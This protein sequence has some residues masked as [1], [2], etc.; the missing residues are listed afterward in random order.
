MGGE[1]WTVTKIFYCASPPIGAHSRPFD[2]HDCPSNAPSG[3][4][5]R[6]S[7]TKWPAR[8]ASLLSG[9]VPTSGPLQIKH[10]RS[11]KC[12]KWCRNGSLIC[13]RSS[14]R[15]NRLGVLAG[16]GSSRQKGE[17]RKTRTTRNGG[18][19]P[20]LLATKGHPPSVAISLL[21]TGKEHNNSNHGLP[22]CQNNIRA[23]RPVGLHEP[24]EAAEASHNS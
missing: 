11:A 9:A 13:G 22:G 6:T 16:D 10:L 7:S 8:C 19:K 4:W 20:Q 14:G 17:P 1:Q 21:R 18:S 24:H 2:A 23:A 5:A 3:A 12:K 15:H